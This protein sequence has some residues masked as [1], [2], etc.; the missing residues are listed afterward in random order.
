MLTGMTKLYC[1]GRSTVQAVSGLDLIV[2]D[3]EWL[4][5][6]DRTGSHRVRQDRAA[7]RARR[8][9]TGLSAG[10]SNWTVTAWHAAPSQA[11]PAARTRSGSPSTPTHLLKL[12]ASPAA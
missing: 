8:A 6:Q 4:A 10:R 7:E 9:W 1:K 3:G 5:V 12:P 11:Y 2:G